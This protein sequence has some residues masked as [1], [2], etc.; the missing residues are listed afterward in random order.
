[1]GNLL[2]KAHKTGALEGAVDDMEKALDGDAGAAA[3]GT[4]VVCMENQGV[5]DRG[6]ICSF[7][8]SYA[9]S[10]VLCWKTGYTQTTHCNAPL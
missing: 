4:H 5:Y 10:F 2:M 9:C 1:M 8:C 7:A 6:R 3:A